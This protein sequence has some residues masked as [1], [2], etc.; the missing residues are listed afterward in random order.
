MFPQLSVMIKELITLVWVTEARNAWRCWR[1]GMVAVVVLI[2]VIGI[3][4]LVYWKL[5][6]LSAEA[7]G[8]KP[9]PGLPFASEA[10][11]LPAPLDQEDEAA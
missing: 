2:A 11:A 8:G 7:R 4:A 5:L 1:R 10:K 9:P 3:L 6:D